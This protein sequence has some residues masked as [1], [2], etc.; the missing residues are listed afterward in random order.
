MKFLL[1]MLQLHHSLI[2]RGIMVPLTRQTRGS[3][4]V[5]NPVCLH[6]VADWIPQGSF[7]FT[8]GVWRV[9]KDQWGK[10]GE[11]AESLVFRFSFPC[12]FAM[13]RLT[14]CYFPGDQ[15]S[16][17]ER[18][19][20]NDDVFLYWTASSLSAPCDGPKAS[21]WDTSSGMHLNCDGEIETGL[22]EMDRKSGFSLLEEKRASSQVMPR[23]LGRRQKSQGCGPWGRL[24]PMRK[25]ACWAQLLSWNGCQEQRAQSSQ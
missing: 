19:R 11:L 4:L 3:L 16:S 9:E 22:W 10:D 20:K 18:L 14:V 5:S 21:L 23:T 24:R 8:T 17:S 2:L 15:L 6:Q 12:G 1:P 13:V 7:L 25:A